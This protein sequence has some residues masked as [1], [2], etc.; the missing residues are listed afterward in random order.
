MTPIFRP[1]MIASGLFA[2]LLA[3]LAASPASAGDIFVTNANTGTV[4]KYTGRR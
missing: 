3:S 2:G 4:G 1:K